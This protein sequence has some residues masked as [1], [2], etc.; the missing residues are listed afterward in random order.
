MKTSPLLHTGESVHC[1]GPAT[2]LA[3]LGAG[4]LK[5]P[6]GQGAPEGVSIDVLQKAPYHWDPPRGS[7]AYGPIIMVRPTMSTTS[8]SPPVAIV[9]AGAVGTALARALTT[10]GYRVDAVLSR[11]GESA[12][13]LATRV[14]ASVAS[15][16]SDALPQT[17]RCVFVCVPD[18]AIGEVAEAL[19]A[20]A[21]PWEQT[22]V[23]HTSGVHTAEALAPLAR[24]GAGTMS[25]HPMQTFAGEAPPSAFEGITVG[26]EGDEGAVAAGQTLAQALGARPLVL[27]AGEKGRYHCAAALASNGLVALMGVVE[28]VFGELHSGD[29]ARVRDVF[30][31]LVEQS[32]T[33]IEQEGTEA[34]LTGPVARGDEETVKAHLKT[35]RT[36]TP[37]L[38]PAYVALSTEAVRLAVRGGQLE[39]E[40][41]QDLLQTLKSAADASISDDYPSPLGR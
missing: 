39:P 7:P 23:A 22:I 41:A 34:A 11:T 17:V 33:N 20:V 25:F 3:S 12:Q 28:E 29:E 8:E 40:R 19:A 4:A 27:T 1:R 21:H 6:G 9:G 30:T 32:W 5:P 13:A 18:D 38:I 36:T 2:R 26:L 37:H 31:P 16:H 14:E 15:T 10:G 24:E 35:L